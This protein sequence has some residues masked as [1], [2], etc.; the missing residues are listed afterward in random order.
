MLKGYVKF[1]FVDAV[2]NEVTRTET[3]ENFI[4][5]T[6]F[7]DMWIKNTTLRQITILRDTPAF[8]A[9]D[10]YKAYYNDTTR[11]FRF[12]SGNTS[13]RVF[14]PKTELEDAY[15]EYY[16]LFNPPVVM[17][18]IRGVALTILGGSNND[19]LNYS[20]NYTAINLD[21]PCT[22][23]PT[24]YLNVY[25]RLILIEDEDNDVPD[26]I[27]NQMVLDINR[28][29]SAK[30][31]F[32]SDMVVL[33]PFR[34]MQDLSKSGHV[35]FLSS[36]GIAL[37]DPGKTYPEQL[38]MRMYCEKSAI[39]PP[40]H[41]N[42]Y[43]TFVGGAVNTKFRGGG[44][45]VN[46]DSPIPSSYNTGCNILIS[47]V[48]ITPELSE[49]FTGIGNVFAANRHSTGTVLFD[50]SNF[51]TGTGR[52]KVGGQLANPEKNPFVSSYQCEIVQGGS[53]WIDAT[54]R[55]YETCNMGTARSTQPLPLLPYGW[56]VTQTWLTTTAKEMQ[57]KY[58]ERVHFSKSLEKYSDN[59]FITW[60]S[61]GITI[62]DIYHGTIVSYDAHSLPVLDVTAIVDV[63]VDSYSNIWIACADTGLFKL[64]IVSESE[65]ILQHI[66]VLPGSQRKCYGIDVDNFGNVW[67]VFWGT[68]LFMSSDGGST[69]SNVVINYLPFSDF[70]DDGFSS[71][72]K[73][74]A[75]IHCDRS[76]DAANGVGRLLLILS[77]SSPSYSTS[78]GCWFDLQSS[79]VVGITNSSMKSNLD[80]ARG[81]RHAP[82]IIVDSNNRWFFLRDGGDLKHCAFLHNAAFSTFNF[83]SGKGAAFGSLRLTK[84]YD[85]ELGQEREYVTTG[86]F[87]RRHSAN[88][89]VMQA[90]DTA[91][92]TYKEWSVGSSGTIYNIVTT[93]SSNAIHLFENV[94]VTFAD[95]TY[96]S[97]GNSY[98]FFGFFL[99]MGPTYSKNTR[100]IAANMYGWDGAQWVKNHP[101]AKPIHLD[102]QV[103]LRGATNKF[104]DGSFATTSWVEK[105]TFSFTVFDG[106]FKDNSTEMSIRD[107]IY[108]KPSEVIT[109]F[110]PSSVTLVDKQSDTGILNAAPI[111]TE[112]NIQ[113]L[114]DTE[115]SG[116]TVVENG[117]PSFSL[118]TFMSRMDNDGFNNVLK[119]YST[120]VG[121]PITTSEMMIL[122]R[123]STYFN[124][125]SGFEHSAS[126]SNA[127]ANSFTVEGF[128]NIEIGGREHT[129]FD[130]RL[131][132]TQGPRIFIT[133]TSRV[134]V[135][136]SDTILIGN[137]GVFL[138]PGTTYHIAITK[139]VNLWRCF[140]NGQLQWE[141]P[142][143]MTSQAS[144]FMHIMKRFARIG[145]TWQGF[146][147]WASNVRVTNA[148]RYT[149]NFTPTTQPFPI[150][151]NSYAGAQ[152]ILKGNH[153]AGALVA[154]KEL[155]GNFS[156]TFDN[157]SQ[158]TQALKNQRPILAFG[159]ST[160]K[161]IESPLDIGYRFVNWKYQIWQQEFHQ[162]TLHTNVNAIRWDKTGSTL[163]FYTSTNNG[164]SFSLQ[165]TTQVHA[166]LFYIAM[167][168][169]QPEIDLATPAVRISSNGSAIF[170]KIGDP[171]AAKGQFHPRFV[172]CD[173][174]T[175]NDVRIT[176]DG[177]APFKVRTNYVD[178]GMPS[179]MEVYAHQHGTITFNEEDLGKEIRGQVVAVRD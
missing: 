40:A 104:E 66:G 29:N 167:W 80:Y 148:I 156:V 30:V 84:L 25:Y 114:P 174:T 164:I 24:E 170:S 154:L 130:W 17:S 136:V 11:H 88:T 54:Y 59:T 33:Y 77:A 175:A 152:L 14:Y 96:M 160:T 93:M 13:S 73:Y 42:Q 135:N 38:D 116:G 83:T 58:P 124:G 8:P 166:P 22:Q 51:A 75:R 157:I 67:A 79:E 102:E 105:E 46:I 125:E 119:P 19:A 143:T 4:F 106:Y 7:M 144:P 70:E 172:A 155:V 108:F 74:L 131:N 49:K 103:L 128:F 32:P 121:D 20:D 69:W 27:R 149:G 65:R 94:W 109:V 44:N 159:I 76:A 36:Y 140:V 145:S 81:N 28:D 107:T 45:G 141:A 56:D 118:V 2:T 100:M 61:T 177:E 87:L 173:V 117:D 153:A 6:N 101:G 57:Y 162:G 10:R 3:H 5:R 133:N 168:Q 71:N 163:S 147:G 31:L 91:L 126:T 112:W 34:I 89:A 16:S 150:E 179:E 68:G 35:N 165:S 48:K 50:A 39:N 115:Y 138:F 62:Y 72:W 37:S 43:S 113:D 63:K 110:E 15:W 55:V 92:L 99:T 23:S 47:P 9:F 137:A 18:T 146:M 53:T 123:Q 95:A 176:L 86:P 78:G 26:F 139:S 21:P 90:V 41:P 12:S 122:G 64:T 171:I 111:T 161:N 82:N 60:D 1:E 132:T 97:I 169:F 158:A 134:A 142:A 129:L 52:M 85:E 120:I 178:P 151:G 98:K 127:L